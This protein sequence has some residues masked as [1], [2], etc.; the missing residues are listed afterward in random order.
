MAEKLAI[1][2]GPKA[3]ARPWPRWP[4]YGEAEIELIAEILRSGNT[5]FHRSPVSKDFE[6]RFAEWNGSKHAVCCNSGTSALHM[7][8]A[9]GGVGPGDEVIVPPRTF[10]GTVSPVLHQSAVPIFAD[11]DPRTHNIS[12][13]AI[14]QVISKRT[15]AIIPVHLAGLPCEMDEIMAIAEEHDLL[16]VEDAA[17]AHG[18]EYKGRKVGTIG[19]INAFSMQDSK[20]LNTTGDG[21]M[22]TTNDDE[23]AI[24]CREF[25]NHGFLSTR[26]LDDLHIYIHPRMGYNYRMT[27]I[28]AAVGLKAMDRLDGYIETRRRNAAF[29]TREIEKIAGL[30]P[31]AEPPGTKCAYYVYYCTMEPEKFRADRD[32]F[33]RALQAEGISVRIGT[34]AELYTQEFFQ[35]K[36]G[37]SWDP[38]I[39]KGKVNYTKLVCSVARKVG[40]ETFA[41][42]VA[43]PAT[44]ADMADVV[45]ALQK[46][47]A[48]YQS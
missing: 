21:G 19:H 37:H 9:A 42:D 36:A 48:A 38:R 20:I 10:I 16:V 47:A 29:L 41:L 11:I 23:A 25:R 26:K 40:Q 43:P 5:H 24:F 32:Q 45:A 4:I 12:P 7:A 31:M 46:V 30:I 14:R 17:Q 15:K 28:Q 44:E 39:Y 18:A 8:L 3:R 27:E 34:S 13:D 1:D 33:V 2:G 35:K 6:K 22:V